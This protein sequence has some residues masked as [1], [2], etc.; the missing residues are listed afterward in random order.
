MHHPTPTSASH[1]VQKASEDAWGNAYLDTDGLLYG[2][3]TNSSL[4]LTLTESRRSKA[5]R[6]I[7][8]QTCRGT[9]MLDDHL[10]LSEDGDPVCQC[11]R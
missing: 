3:V 2:A 5:A 4:L 7:N 10:R 6:H 1:D 11:H 9:S 8:L